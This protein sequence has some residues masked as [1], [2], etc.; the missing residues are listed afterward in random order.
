MPILMRSN[1]CTPLWL[2]MRQQ[3]EQQQQQPT[4]RQQQ[5]LQQLLHTTTDQQFRWPTIIRAT[6]AA[7]ATLSDYLSNQRY[8][9]THKYEVQAYFQRSNKPRG[10]SLTTLL[11][12]R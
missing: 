2:A 12:Q 3:Y 1:A 11:Y 4:I 5:I 8:N 6:A 10:I 7:A 9:G